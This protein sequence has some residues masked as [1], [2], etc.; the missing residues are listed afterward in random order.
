MKSKKGQNSISNLLVQICKLRRNKS[1]ILLSDAGIHGGQDILLYYLSIEDGQTVSAL[2]E[3]MCIQHATISTMI[4]R[5]QASGMIK[6]VKDNIDKRT[7]R[8]F[9]TEQGQQAY[10]QIAEI[11][12]I[13]ETTVIK[14]LDTNQQKTLNGL[15]QIV[16]KNLS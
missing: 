11:W 12:K 3:K 14:G 7:S 15:L 9:I 2:V 1:N 10:K 13:M 4:D 6:K 5:M 16:L 8:V